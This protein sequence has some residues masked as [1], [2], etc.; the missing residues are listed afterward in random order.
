MSKY[1]TRNSAR[2]ISGIWA[3]MP[4]RAARAAAIELVNT[5]HRGA[6]V[7]PTREGL[8]TFAGLF[9]N[10]DTPCIW[11]IENN[12]LS[13]GQ[14]FEEALPCHVV[15][16]T[17]HG[18]EAVEVVA[19]SRQQLRKYLAAN[20]ES[21]FSPLRSGDGRNEARTLKIPRLECRRLL[22]GTGRL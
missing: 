7:N 18:C 22:D 11:G 1:T 10:G 16:A 14:Q 17:R 13:A 9:E 20:G 6:P 3:E 8:E 4:E 12:L 5:Q 21:H 15:R 2:E 19:G